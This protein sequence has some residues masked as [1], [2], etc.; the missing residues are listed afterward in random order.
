MLDINKKKQLVALLKRLG[1]DSYSEK[2]VIDDLQKEIELLK[3]SIPAEVDLS[4]YF[5]D[6]KSLQSKYSSLSFSIV[7]LVNNIR[8]TKE[9]IIQKLQ[10]SD[11][12]NQLFINET[13]ELFT[14]LG[15]ELVRLEKE[16]KKP[17]G[18][19]AMH[20]L[21]ANGGALIATRYTDLNFIGSG[22]TITTANNDVTKRTDI[23]L[24]ASGG[25]LTELLATGLVNS[26]NRA[27]TFTT[28][29]TYIVSDG[30]WYKENKGWTWSGLTATMDIPPNVAIWGF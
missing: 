21:L 23:T 3:E 17:R 1:D 4:P 22:V 16:I 7:T 13:T 19:G 15:G 2:V 8:E 14:K 11:Q 10:S 6:V 9:L 18:G 5:T 27:F 28:K 26:V 30:A 25:G 29:P 20:R 24:T 12:K